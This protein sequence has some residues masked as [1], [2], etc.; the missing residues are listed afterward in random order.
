[1]Q[2]ILRAYPSRCTG[3]YGRWWASSRPRDAGLW[4]WV[5]AAFVPACFVLAEPGR[6]AE[7]EPSIPH[8][9]RLLPQVITPAGQRFLLSEVDVQIAYDAQA[10]RLVTSHGDWWFINYPLDRIEGLEDLSRDK[11]AELLFGGAEAAVRNWYIRSRGS[12]VDEPDAP[13]GPAPIELTPNPTLIVDGNHPDADDGNTGTADAP[14][15]TIQAAVNRARPG[16]VI[17]VYPGVYR[18]S[19]TSGQRMDVHGRPVQRHGRHGTRDR[20]IRIEGVR[21]AQ[22]RMPIISGNDVFPDDAWSPIPE[23]PGVYRADLFTQR[24]GTVSLAGKALIEGNA[25]DALKPDMFHVNR[26]SRAFLRRHVDVNASPSVG[27]LHADRPWRHAKVDADGHLDLHAV[28]GDEA[29]DAVIWAS[30]WLWIEPSDEAAWNP[31]FPE[32]VVR[33]VEVA[34]PFRAA[35]MAGTHLDDQ[36]NKY[37]V[38]VNGDLVPAITET[39]SDSPRASWMYGFTDRWR[40][41][42]FREGWN[43]LMFQFDTTTTTHADHGQIDD[44]LRF[45]FAPG[46]VVSA[47]ERPEA[48]SPPNGERRDYVSEYLVW[49]PVPADGPDHGVYVRLPNDQN[50]NDVQLDLAARGSGLV[51]IRNAFTHFRGFEIRHGAQFQQQAQVFIAGEGSL[52]EGCLVQRSEWTGIEFSVAEQDRDV[53]ATPLVIRNNWIVD[54][55]ATGIAGAGAP[56]RTLTATTRDYPYPGNVPLVVEH[57]TVVNHGR[58]GVYGAMD[59]GMKMFDLKHAVIRYNTIRGGYSDFGGIWLDW[60]HYN[61]RVEGNLSVNGRASGISLE[62]SPGPLLVANN[63][64]IGLRPG[65]Q[66]FRAGILAWDTSR[67]WSIHNTIDGQ[68]DQ[69]KGWQGEVGTRGIYTGNPTQRELHAWGVVQSENHRYFNNLLVGA[70]HAMQSHK[71][72]HDEGE[73]N[74]TDR[75]HGVTP[76]PAPPEFL[77]QRPHDYRLH[78]EQPAEG[79]GVSNGYTQLV[80]HDFHGLLRF[81]EDSH[82]VGAF[83]VHR[84]IPANVHT[85]VEVEFDDGEMRR[86]TPH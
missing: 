57:N 50:P 72:R 62:A 83:R 75:G 22:Q 17:H 78:P 18:E 11:V 29:R 9:P 47:A 85:V 59:A 25:P 28:F 32:P 68:W 21:D 13:R 81:A 26:A 55:G 84:P 54:V 64:V 67:V 6:L 41:F 60:G 53:T 33:G 66:W 1:M 7:P 2:R 42:P 4:L 77:L 51:T 63:L 44:T 69:T 27:E 52:L 30:T 73:A 3:Q 70:E 80:R 8:N 10:D 82:P 74:Y 5:L 37:R 31:A 79:L 35:R 23:W 34:G 48:C 76:L 65:S 20:P 24:P 86:R 56:E 43:H 38:W 58:R 49:G 61:N 14:L 39:G 12:S 46:N 40:G 16:E 45:H 71:D 15:R 36:V 19:V